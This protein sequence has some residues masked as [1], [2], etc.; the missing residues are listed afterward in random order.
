MCVKSLEEE[1]MFNAGHLLT[2]EEPQAEEVD[3][4]NTPKQRLRK[5][6]GRSFRHALTNLYIHESGRLE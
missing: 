3:Q 6:P 4:P 2:V 5:K 1:I